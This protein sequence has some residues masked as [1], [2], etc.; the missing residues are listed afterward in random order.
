MNI[1]YSQ[2]SQEEKTDSVQRYCEKQLEARWYDYDETVD[3]TSS[4]VDRL[5]EAFGRL[6][7]RLA[8]QGQLSAMN[9]VYVCSG[10]TYATTAKFTEDA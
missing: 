6:V 10:D 9:V 8:S 2:G 4:Q 7:D 3:V 1:T 5:V